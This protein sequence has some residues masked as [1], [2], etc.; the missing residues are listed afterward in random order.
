MAKK[1]T[2]QYRQLKTSDLWEGVELKNMLVDV[3]RRQGWTDNAK[4]RK[5]DLDQDGSIVILNKVSL[6]DTWDGPVFAGQLIHLQE[7]TEVHAVIQS[8]DD[9]AVEYPLTSL[10]VGEQA[11]VLKGALYFAVVGNHVGVI[12]G[13]QVKGRTL[14][15]YL[16]A[17]LI[18]AA[19]LEDGQHITLNSKFLTGDGKELSE[20]TEITVNAA[21]SGPP[22]EVPAGDGPAMVVERE[23]GGAREHEQATVFE[24]LRG[25]VRTHT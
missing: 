11:R 10:D 1:S 7:G 12:E 17:L 16:T 3:L 8:L 23:A 20:L 24:V 2:I 14:E 22:G 21:R 4:H 6:P 18:R 13:A 15:R 19:E 25:C 9:D 5:I